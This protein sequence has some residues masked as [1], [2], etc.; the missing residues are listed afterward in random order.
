M[1]AGPPFRPSQG[2]RKSPPS[3]LS[4]LERRRL[5]LAA[6][7]QAV[8]VLARLFLDAAVRVA[9][10]RKIGPLGGWGWQ[11]VTPDGDV[12]SLDAVTLARFGAVTAKRKTGEGRTMGN[13]TMVDRKAV[14][15]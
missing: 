7:A 15:R 5:G 4:H 11:A 1:Y 12:T 8:R 13:R 10:K 6:F 3:P 14:V 9:G 2:R